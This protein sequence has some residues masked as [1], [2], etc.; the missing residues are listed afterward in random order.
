M[1]PEGSLSLSWARLIQ[2]MPPASHV[3]KIVL[4]SSSYIHLDLP[5]DL[6]PTGFPIKT[7]YAPLLLPIHAT[8]LGRLSKTNFIQS[9]WVCYWIILS[10]AELIQ[11]WWW[12]NQYGALLEVHTG[13]N[14]SVWGKTALVF[15]CPL[16]IM[17]WDQTKAA[18]VR[19]QQLTVWGTALYSFSLILKQEH[20]QM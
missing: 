4:I 17:A 6:L 14:Q 12:L 20:D 1:E 15:L 5:N 13:E 11:R 16:H 7:L 2:S 8:C 3:L 18:M 9:I 19:G 10:V